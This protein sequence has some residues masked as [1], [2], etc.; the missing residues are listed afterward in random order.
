M[1]HAPSSLWKKSSKFFPKVPIQFKNT[2]GNFKN[3]DKFNVTIIPYFGTLKN[4][5]FKPIPASPATSIA[6]LGARRLQAVCSMHRRRYRLQAVCSMHCRRY[7][8]QAVCSMH[9]RR[10]RKKSS[11]FFQVPIQFKNTLGNFKKETNH[12][13]KG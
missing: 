2:L 4:Q 5:K 12:P 9:R 3:K 11:K 10:Y 8:L 6:R 7:R 13:I 1:L